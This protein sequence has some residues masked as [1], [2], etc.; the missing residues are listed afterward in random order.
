MET[1]TIDL[2][3]KKSFEIGQQGD[4]NALCIHFI[5]MKNVGTNKKYIYY[6]IDGIENC[7]PLTNDR[8]IV[9]YPLTAHSGIASAQLISKLNDNSIIKLSNVF[10]MHIKESKGYKDSG[11]YPVD[12]NIQSS[13]DLL[14][15]LINETK[16]LINN[17]N[18][19]T[20]MEKLTQAS[21]EAT[22]SAATAKECAD[23]LKNSTDFIN[24][25]D[26]K[27]AAQDSKIEK[28]EASTSHITTKQNTKIAALKTR[29][30]EFTSLKDGS[31]TGDAELID[32]RIGADGTKYPSA[33]DAMRGQVEQLNED[34]V[35]LEKG[36]AKLYGEF[37]YGSIEE[38]GSLFQQ[39]NRISTKNLLTY[40]ETKVLKSKDGFL[41]II[42][43]FDN[44]NSVV[45]RKAGNA[46]YIV[47]KGTK[48][49]V[50]IYRKN[51]LD[52]EIVDIPT[53]CQNVFL[54]NFDETYN[55]HSEEIEN[56]LSDR[57]SLNIKW[58]DAGKAIDATNGN[59]RIEPGCY[60]SE[61]FYYVK[62]GNKIKSN[63]VGTGSAIA[64]A[65][66][67]KNVNFISGI[68]NKAGNII[69]SSVPVNAVYAR[70]TSEKTVSDVYVTFGTEKES[71]EFELK[72]FN[73]GTSSSSA[74]ETAKTFKPKMEKIEHRYV[75]EVNPTK[76]YMA[77]GF[78]DLRDSDVDMVIP[79]FNKYGF[80][81]E[82][83]KI[84]T[85]EKSSKTDNDK[86]S[87][88]IYSG[89][90]LGDHT[91]KHLQFMYSDPMFDGS[92]FPTN[93]QM[94][95]DR[96]DGKNV[97]GRLLTNKVSEM[98]GISINTPWGEL[99][100]GECQS[101]RE[102]YS[103]LKSPTGICNLLDA[104]S[105][106]YLDTT[107]NSL[108]GGGI[109][110][111][112]ITTCNHEIWERL[113]LITNMYYKDQYGLNC[114]FKTWSMPGDKFSYCRFEK[115]G[116]LFYDAECTKP[117]NYL[118]KMASSL[119]KNEDGTIKQ[120]SW[121]DV[122]REFGY[123][124]S[125]DYLYPS[126]RDGQTKPIMSNQYIMNASESRKDAIIYPTNRTITYENAGAKYTQTFFTKGKDYATQM[127]EDGGEFYKFV[128][129][130]RKDTSNGIIHG[131]LIDSVDSYGNRMLLEKMLDYCKKTGVE[132]I[133]KSE[134]YDIC[135]NHTVKN[136]NL[137]YNPQFRNTAKEY[138]PLASNLSTIPDGY[139]NDCLV[140]YDEN[141]V[142]VL[143]I[144]ENGY[145]V[146]YYQYGIPCGKLRF[147]VDVKG[148]NLIRIYA[149]KN[150]ISTELNNDDMELLAKISAT[151]TKNFANIVSE[152]YVNRN[153]ITE[154]DNLCDGYG[155]KICG[156][157]IIYGQGLSIKNI[158]LELIN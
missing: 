80:K 128:E 118:A 121:T 103:V 134:A 5:N 32:A 39:K 9:G 31:T 65:F 84:I 35:S 138:V 126:K 135:F 55:L 60:C 19:A 15:D 111:G 62:S 43:I 25:L 42:A 77:I 20:L 85:D 36:N 52:G 27:V 10:A 64:I 29:M 74:N 117:Y 63:L 48:F 37:E 127:Y 131:E 158:K 119:Y 44:T 58:S 132:V 26:E 155:E 79:I 41:F 141:N 17:Y 14:D 106:K 12:P 59:V 136:G 152:F 123:E 148:E 70:F 151:D 140:K 7:V 91:I 108:N 71:D 142:P 3:K 67:D 101:I 51:E 53:F 45:L 88:V 72:Y 154:N 66:Y 89:H 113:L 120:R 104:L 61:N 144:P 13:Y 153:K 156:I 38:D 150:K 23:E 157:K 145:G 78:D 76:R 105:N 146:S 81:A 56:R 22:T 21:S 6:T 11:E 133:T 49:K 139:E 16:D 69:D 92:T 33:G 50:T 82:F 1:L 129:E 18:Y 47:K 99:S 86:V 98:D 130:I 109:F 68:E 28:I 8:F 57:Y 34:L 137:I 110:T 4:H 94:R 2:K 100:D 54:Y 149:Y 115:D 73:C 107:G 125:H 143:V 97:F 116:K 83:N 124:S 102:Y 24:T 112:C 87:S 147:S 96:G 95:N 114:D 40:D 90:E 30:S 46:E 93:A 75:G 122:L